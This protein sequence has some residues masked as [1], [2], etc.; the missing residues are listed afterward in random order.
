MTKSS[1]GATH[2]ASAAEEKWGPVLPPTSRCR[3]VLS[4]CGR[5]FRS[6]DGRHHL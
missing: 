3:A 2:V 6:R 1:A 5:G 4:A